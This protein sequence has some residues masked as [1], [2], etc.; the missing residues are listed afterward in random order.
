VANSIADRVN[1]R[2]ADGTIYAAGLQEARRILEIFIDSTKTAYNNFNMEKH[3]DDKQR[4][5]DHNS[6]LGAQAII[7]YFLLF[8]S[9]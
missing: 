5:N 6:I 1:D 8:C 4:H 2:K 9:Q 7:F 3:C